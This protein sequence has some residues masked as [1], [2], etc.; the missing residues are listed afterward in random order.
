MIEEYHVYEQ[1]NQLTSA[2]V[3]LGWK[4]KKADETT[5]WAW[6][7]GCMK[8]MKRLGFTCVLICSFNCDFFFYQPTN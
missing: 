2:D 3:C 1:Q 8:P 4:A 5:P 7:L 6:L